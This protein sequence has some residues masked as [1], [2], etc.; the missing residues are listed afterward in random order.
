M[1]VYDFDNTVYNGESCVDFFFFCLTK[2]FTLIK[3]LPIILY[4]AALY[5]LRLLKI[6]K[7]YDVTGNISFEFARNNIPLERIVD[8]FWAAHDKKIKPYFREKIQEN[9]LIISASPRFLIED[10]IKKRWKCDLI[11]SEFDTETGT[12]EFVCYRENKVKAFEK[13]YPG[14]VITELYTD[15]LNDIYLMKVAQKSFLVQKGNPPQFIEMNE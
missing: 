15:S 3:Y 1:T 13:K 8:E 12:F 7:L 9:D 4:T 5:K 6:E 2:K 10:I 11:C 14:A